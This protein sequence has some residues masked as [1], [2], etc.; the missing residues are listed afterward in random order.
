MDRSGNSVTFA[1]ISSIPANNRDS[2]FLISKMVN[3]VGNNAGSHGEFDRRGVDDA[4]DIARAWSRNDTEE[5]TIHSILRVKLDHLL[6][7]V[8]TL[9]ELDTRIEWS[10][11]CSE[12]DLDTADEWV[13]RI[14][15]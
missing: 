14:G 9:K 3:R 8:R 7:V 2:R 5:G 6:V 10:T 1:V 13:E 4:H 12:K 15:T 11:I